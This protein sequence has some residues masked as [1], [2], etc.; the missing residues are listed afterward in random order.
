[1]V[2]KFRQLDF[3]NLIY[4][5]MEQSNL[6]KFRVQHLHYVQTKPHMICCKHA[7]C[8]IACTDWESGP[9]LFQIISATHVGG[10]HI[11]NILVSPE[12]NQIY[13]LNKLANCNTNNV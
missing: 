9:A 1:M 10:G 6:F 12:Y 3:C 5:Y 11:S 8:Y 7:I 4:H 13:V 2:E